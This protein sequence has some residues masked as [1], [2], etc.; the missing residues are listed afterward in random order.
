M[1][2]SAPRMVTSICCKLHGS[3]SYSKICSIY[4]KTFILNSLPTKSKGTHSN[5]P[6]FLAY[7]KD[8]NDKNK[9]Y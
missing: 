2:H 5:E 9:C 6:H 7:K 8:S 4:L 3:K 1:Q